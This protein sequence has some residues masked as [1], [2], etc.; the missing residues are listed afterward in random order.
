MMGR[1]SFARWSLYAFLLMA[2]LS[3]AYLLGGRDSGLDDLFSGDNWSNAGR[4]LRQLAGLDSDA[5]PAF[6][7]G[8]RWLET[9]KLAWDTL[10][11]SVLAIGMTGLAAFPT[12]MFGARNVGNG[13]LGGPPPCSTSSST[14]PSGPPSPCPAPCRNW[15]GP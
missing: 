11:M 4:F 5:T 9:G 7:R 14:T 6:A 3:W 13:Q 8:D 10:A 15:S 1:V 12:F 2:A